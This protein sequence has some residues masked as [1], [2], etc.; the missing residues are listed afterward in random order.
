VRSGR[1][2]LL[3]DA[4]AARPNPGRTV[5]TVAWPDPAFADLQVTMLPP[6]TGRGQGE[7]GRGGLAFWQD[8]GTYLVLNMWL[9]DWEGHDGSSISMFLSAN[10]QERLYDAV[11]TN[12]GR[13]VTWGRRFTLRASCDGRRVLAWLDGE[14]ILYR[15]LRDIH[16]RLAPMQLRRVG[17][18]ANWE[19]GDDTG[20]EF[21]DFVARGRRAAE[22]P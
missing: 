12:V 3:V 1:G 10:G 2:S 17:L 16:P 15:E 11:W 20:T 5:Y 4:C 19:W 6:G 7:A 8:P 14:P 9:D 13:R 18:A 22:G 21:T